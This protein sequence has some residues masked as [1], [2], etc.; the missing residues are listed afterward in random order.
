MND[1]NT[2]EV[3]VIIGAASGMGEACARRMNDKGILLL[4]DVNA[5]RLHALAKE[6]AGNGAK[7]EAEICDVSDKQSVASLVNKCE[8]LGRFKILIDTA[9]IAPVQCDDWKRIMSVNLVGMAIVL[10]TFLPLANPGASVVCIASLAGYHCPVIPE[11]DEILDKP[12]E[13]HFPVIITPFIEGLGRTYGNLKALSYL[14]SKRG[15]H[16]LIKRQAPYWHA[17]GT[18]INSRSPGLIQ[19]PMGLRQI[20]ISPKVM[21]PLKDMTVWKRMG[22][23]DEIAGPVNFLCSP[24]A[25]FISGCDIIIDGGYMAESVN[26]S[27][28]W[29]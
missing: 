25:S 22:T 20:E 29:K 27:S 18:R 1:N 21:K 28:W 19:S 5:S 4:A 8:N 3:C 24:D 17:R 23:P 6:L 2:G 16:R 9:G 14:L 10:E 26:Q 13:P 7:V 15:V 11:I 12:L